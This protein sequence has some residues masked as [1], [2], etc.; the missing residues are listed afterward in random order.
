MP[1]AAAVF[2]ENQPPMRDLVCCDMQVKTD[3]VLKP[4]ALDKAER[5]IR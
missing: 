2:V 1:A 4:E 5:R 3:L